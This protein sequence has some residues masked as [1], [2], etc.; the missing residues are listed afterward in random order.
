MCD[1]I[2]HFMPTAKCGFHFSTSGVVVV[3]TR[4]NVLL[5]AERKI[6]I[7]PLSLSLTIVFKVAF[8]IALLYLKCAF[9]AVYIQGLIQGCI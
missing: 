5:T 8:E 2:I 4:D 9:E 3:I 6:L 1:D 7:K